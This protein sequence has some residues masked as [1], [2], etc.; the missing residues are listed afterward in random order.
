MAKLK[1][2][3]VNQRLRVAFGFYIN[4]IKTMLKFKVNEMIAGKE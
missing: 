4:I 1:I 3:A 2:K